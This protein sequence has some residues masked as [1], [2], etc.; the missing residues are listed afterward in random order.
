MTRY[1]NVALKRT[2]V[3][4][5]FNYREADEGQE[6]AG[7]SQAPEDA[8]SMPPAKRRRSRKAQKVSEDSAEAILDP[9]EHNERGV[10]PTQSDVRDAASVAA[11]SR[12]SRGKAGADKKKSR[13]GQKRLKGGADK[14]SV[15]RKKAH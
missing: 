15:L 8:P 9:Q 7:P 2:H 11:A 13:Q 5:G 1:A 4:A 14:R 6:D 10:D 3:Q 12:Q